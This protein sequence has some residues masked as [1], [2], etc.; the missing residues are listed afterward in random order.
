MALDILLFYFINSFVFRNV[1]FDGAAI[2]LVHYL[3]FVL[4]GVVFIFLFYNFKK[5]WRM[6]LKA[7][8]A[9]LLSFCS[10]QVI[11]ALFYRSRPFLVAGVKNILAHSP[12]PS[13]PSSHA[14]VLFAI[15]TVVVLYNKKAGTL[16]LI[17]AGL[18]SL[19]RVFCAV[20][21]PSDIMGGMTIGIL[22][23]LLIHY[24]W[25]KFWP[26]LKQKIPQLT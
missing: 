5:Y 12:S 11:G 4:I 19:A 17:L 1:Y 3:P 9:G 14:T 8:A 16:F 15:A 21:W 20:H 22:S 23:A 2:F 18:V 26:I 24:L 10:A 7:F 25:Q 6:L 13:F